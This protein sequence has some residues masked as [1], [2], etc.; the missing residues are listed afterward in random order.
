VNDTAA[1]RD[2]AFSSPCPG[3]AGGLHPRRGYF[4]PSHRFILL[5]ARPLHS[6]GS[7]I[8]F[9]FPLTAPALDATKES[10]SGVSFFPQFF[11]ALFS[12]R[13]DLVQEV[14]GKG[15]LFSVCTWQTF[16]SR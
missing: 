4:F 12:L 13:V 7:A 14:S 10:P 2:S 16:W 1:S 3:K 9:P 6:K 8:F 11:P 5:L 15:Y